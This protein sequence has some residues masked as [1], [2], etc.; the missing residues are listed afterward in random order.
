MAAG[1]PVILAIDG[2]IRDVIE[3]AQAGVVVSP[4]DAESL[5]NAVRS[6]AED[7]QK[8]LTLGQNGRRYVETYFDRAVVAEKLNRLLEEILA[9]K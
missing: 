1:R 7:R 5:A 4:G 6:L 3:A 9:E 8:G 2:V